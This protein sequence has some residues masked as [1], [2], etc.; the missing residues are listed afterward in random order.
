MPGFRHVILPLLAFFILGCGV[1]P[2]M[3][4]AFPIS[5]EHARDAWDALAQ[6]RK[7]FDR[8][9][10]VL[11]GIY[12]PGLASSSI[13]RKLRKS[14]PEETQVIA[15]GYPGF[16]TFDRC[17]QKAVDALERRFPS[18]D[19]RETV[20]VDVVGYSMGGIVAR[21]AALP[22]DTGRKRLRVRRLFT[23]ASPHR[24]AR[25]AVLPIFFDPRVSD[26]R[27]GSALLQRLDDHLVQQP[28]ELTCYALLGDITVGAKNTAP[29][30]MHPHW[31]P[32]PPLSL[33]H[34][35][36]G[37]DKRLLLDIV[38]RLRGEETITQGEPT[39][40]P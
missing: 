21:F 34:I 25:L 8:P 36:A 15:V 6:R 22:N 24:G 35:S 23:I 2:R 18:E 1:S 29:P 11:G 40:V 7:P 32:N 14:T 31:L 28:Y 39:P 16:S 12:D 9:V 30:G 27:A 5:D 38:K 19:E 3:N 37:F 26:M 4:P 20:D 17:A 10:L 13:A 33:G